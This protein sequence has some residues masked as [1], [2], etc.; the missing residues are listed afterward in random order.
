M[1]FNGAKKYG[2]KQ[3]DVA[4]EAAGGRNNAYTDQDVT[5]Y[6]DWFP[7]TALE[8]IFDLESD[9]IKNLAFVP[10]IIESERRVVASERRAS[11]SANNAGLL[12]EQLW[13]AAFTGHPY[14][15][16]V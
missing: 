13:A 6:Q 2:P 16:P 7:S 4:M 11:V 3:F 5:V 14:Q 8:L 9:R 12:D 15:W 1:M 10:Q